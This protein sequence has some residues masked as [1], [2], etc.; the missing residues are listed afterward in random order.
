LV[1][2]ETTDTLPADCL[3]PCSL[4]MKFKK[5]ETDELDN[6]IMELLKEVKPASTLL[7]DLKNYFDPEDYSQEKDA[8]LALVV[9]KL[10]KGC[11]DNMFLIINSADLVSTGISS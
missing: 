7:E 5:R 11:E 10:R 8:L 6:L 9:L 1:Y 3:V 2:P 4:E